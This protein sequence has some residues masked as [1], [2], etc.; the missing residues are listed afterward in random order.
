[1]DNIWKL[2]LTFHRRLRVKLSKNMHFSVP[3]RFDFKVRPRKQRHHC[4]DPAC[5]LLTTYHYTIRGV[6]WCTA[7]LEHTKIFF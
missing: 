3:F 7:P 1:M 5:F 6:I 2:P 4:F